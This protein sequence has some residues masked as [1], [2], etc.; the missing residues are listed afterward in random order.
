[1]YDITTLKYCNSVA[2]SEMRHGQN[3]LGNIRTYNI[4]ENGLVNIK[5]KAFKKNEVTGKRVTK[6]YGS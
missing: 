4:V 2:I 6:T 5:V 1:M 3:A